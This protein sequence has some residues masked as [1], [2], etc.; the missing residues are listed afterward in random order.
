M[1]DPVPDD[2]EHVM[3]VWFDALTNYGSGVDFLN[4]TDANPLRAFWPATTHVIGKDIIWFHCVIWPIMLLSA[5]VPLPRGVFAHGFVNDAL[6]KKMSKSVGNVIDPNEILDKYGPDTM[7]FY[8]I[9]E[10]TYG[11]DMPFSEEHLVDLHNANLADGIGNLLRRG[12]A[13][14]A[15][16][17]PGPAADGEDESKKGADKYGLV[18]DEPS[19]VPFDTAAFARELMTLGVGSG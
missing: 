16:Y 15:K 10:T 2:S 5:E 9:C 19:D 11:E 17:R 18:P 8:T 3:Y 12:L 7:R 1:G 13:L 14:C 4:Q 6:G